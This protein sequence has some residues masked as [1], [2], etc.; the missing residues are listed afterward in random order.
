M[1]FNTWI[2]QP[3]TINGLAV[4]LGTLAATISHLSSGSPALDSLVA[5]IGYAFMHVAVN[6]N[7][8]PPPDAAPAA[9]RAVGTD[10]GGTDIGPGVRGVVQHAY[11]NLYIAEIQ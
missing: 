1:D 4:G 9:A 7:S 8:V 3:T 5:A 2:R 6:D 11:R 10:Q